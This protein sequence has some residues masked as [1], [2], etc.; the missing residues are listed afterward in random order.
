[1][2]GKRRCLPP[3]L[4]LLALAGCAGAPR[5][6]EGARLVPLSEANLQAVLAE[7]EG[8]EAAEEDLKELRDFY[9]SGAQQKAR[10]EKKFQEMAYPE[11]MQLYRQSNELLAT[12]LVNLDE[13]T[14]QFPLFEGTHILFFPNL[15]MADN[16]F[17]MGVIMRS[18]GRDAPARRS[19]GKALSFVRKSLRFEKT[20]WGLALEKEIAE[21]LPQKK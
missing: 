13:D 10:A 3:I 19:W 11:A 12:L 2:A 17:K 14:A 1:M 9:R 15:L 18:M 21:L 8:L 20:E 4:L 5:H 6:P 7:N 16:H